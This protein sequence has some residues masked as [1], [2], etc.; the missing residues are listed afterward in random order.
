M[1]RF[2]TLDVSAQ[3]DITGFAIE[4][5]LQDLGEQFQAPEEGQALA[6]DDAIAAFQRGDYRYALTYICAGETSTS[7]PRI[8]PMFA[9]AN[10]APSLRDLWRRFACARSVA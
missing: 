1:L 4:L 6:A 10:A 2:D 3:R 5:F 7:K 8:S 9:K